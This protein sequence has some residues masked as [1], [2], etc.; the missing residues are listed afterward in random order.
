LPLP[1]FSHITRNSVSSSRIA[2]SIKGDL[3]QALTHALRA[4]S[5]REAG[6]FRPYQPLD[7]ISLRDIYL[8]KGD[9]ANAQFHMQQ[10]STLAEEMG[11]STL[12]SS[13]I[14]S[15]NR[16]GDQKEEA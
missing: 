13:M 9:T 12:V 6:G 15:T 14:D 10:A 16:L 3:E 7:H 8:K 11:F 5:F 4:L 2:R 1:C